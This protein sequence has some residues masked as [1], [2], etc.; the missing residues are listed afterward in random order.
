MKL[1]IEKKELNKSLRIISNVISNIST[2][3][4]FNCILLETTD[5]KITIIGSNSL[6]SVKNTISN[7]LNIESNGVALLNGK[8]FYNIVNKINA[9][10]V[11]LEL[12]DNSVL[13]I[14]ADTFSFDINTQEKHTYP[15]IN[16]DFT[17]YEKIVISSKFIKNVISKLS[18]TV[19]LTENFR[20]V[21]K[22]IL[23]DSSRVNGQIEALSTDG[24][25]LAYIKTNFNGPKFKI[26]INVQILKYINELIDQD[27]ELNIYIQHNNL[28]IQVKDYLFSCRLIEG[29]YPSPTK[30]IEE[31]KPLHFLI[32][33]YKFLNALEKG[34]IVASTDKKPSV[35]L[36][37]TNNILKITCRSIELGTSYEELNIEGYQGED[38]KISLNVNALLSLITNIE[39]NK[40]EFRFLSNITPIAVLDPKNTEY[41]S[42]ILPIKTT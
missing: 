2:N 38:I 12:I 23:I 11:N 36:N 39:D 42:I 21:L 10:K 37:I 40:I 18:N 13:R 22:G 28:I 41:Y 35:L 4:I 34:L 19:S 1:T 16:F 26:I 9:T 29:E 30:A 5:N 24:V 25:H 15:S 27:Q 20:T 32:H 31:T 8:V 3:P 33:K 17:S 7:G 6:I 14:S